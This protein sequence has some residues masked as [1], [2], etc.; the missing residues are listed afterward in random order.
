MSC[1]MCELTV[2]LPLRQAK[3]IDCGH[4]LTPS[5]L[6]VSFVKGAASLCIYIRF[7]IRQK[8]TTVVDGFRKRARKRN[9]LRLSDRA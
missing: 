4:C 8:T 5:A 2:E 1:N 7:A 9:E 3:S 6:H